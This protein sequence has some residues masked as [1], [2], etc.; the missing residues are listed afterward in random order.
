MENAMKKIYST[1]I[2]FFALLLSVSASETVEGNAVIRGRITTAEGSAAPD[3]AI[4]VKGS[5]KGAISDDGGNFLIRGLAAGSYELHISLVGYQEVNEKVVLGANE[6]SVINIRLQLT[7][8][9]LQEVIIRSGVRS[10]RAATVS[11]SLRLQAPLLEIPQNIQVVTGK[12]LSDQQ[13]ISM[14][15][16]V[17]RNVSGAVRMEHWGDMYTNISSRGS[18]IQAFRNGFNMVNSYWGPLTEDMSFVDHIEFVKGPAGFMLGNGD[19]SGMYNVVT[20][21]PSGQTKGEAGFTIGS[22]DLYRATLDLDGKLSEDGKLLYRFNLAGQQK[23][24]HRANEFNNRYTFAPVI[25]YQLDEKT[26]LTAEY[27]WQYAKMSDVGSFYVFSTDG[28]A[29]LPVGFTQLPAG[30]PAT[31]INDHSALLNI[32]H[33]LGSK[34]KLTGQLAYS[35]YYQNGSSMWPNA[36]NTN[37]TMIRAVGSWE[38]KSTMTMGQF[39]LN[40]DVTTGTVRHRILGGIDVASK[41]YFAD[42]GQ[43]HALDTVGAEFDTRNPYLGTP[44]NGYPHFDY[45]TPLEQRATAIGGTMALRNTGV[46]LQDELGFLE[47]R[48]RLTLAARYT[49]VTQSEWGG[50]PTTA[51]RFT[52]RIGL[53]FSLDKQTTVYGLFDEAFI[54]QAGKL[55][56]G[57]KVKPITGSNLEFGIKHDWAGGRWNTG[58]SV[59]RILKNNEL[60]ADPFSAPTSGLSIVMGQKKAQGV[61]FDLKGH[62]AKG[63]DL[64]A[65]YAYTDSKVTKVAAG[66]T[67]IKVGDV[68]PGYATHTANAWIT[69]RL[70]D[71]A[72]KGLGFSAGYMFLDGRNTFWD[73]SPDP[74][75]VLPAY[76]KVDAGLSYEKDKM[77]ISLNVFNV[78]NKYLYSGS[79]YA[80]LSAYNWQ[81]DPPRNLRLGVNFR[82]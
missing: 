12:A 1:V 16:G 25:S 68:V 48:I 6:T 81:T 66:V 7:Q 67:S 59:Y 44:V 36:V 50:A 21:K 80:W 60:T 24:S 40:G 38:A 34:W 78:M 53:S 58:L 19:P 23:K 75:K 20:K 63:L 18:Q 11:S 72:L 27:T 54:P 62:I 8:K 74:A 4:Q 65:N 28:F 41:E 57:R 52:P 14:S 61:E 56:G 49:T 45:S 76:H 17:I 79:Y 13:V 31:N 51:D 2:C 26:K 73:V 43:S 22:F 64:V 55:A 39:F 82:F 70:Q 77:T 33:Q 37:G 29:T 47:N 3:V 15:D 10:Y 35:N 42:W 5:S 46:Y 9:E 30:L 32:Q 71:G 69:Y